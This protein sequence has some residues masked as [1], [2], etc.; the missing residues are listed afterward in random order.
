[1]GREILSMQQRVMLLRCEEHG[2]YMPSGRAE[3]RTLGCLKDRELVRL[4]ERRWLLTSAGRTIL[5]DIR[6]RLEQRRFAGF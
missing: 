1:M 3:L 2:G 6:K 4:E 5:N